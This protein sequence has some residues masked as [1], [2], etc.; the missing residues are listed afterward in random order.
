MRSS[1]N[2]LVFAILALTSLAATSVYQCPMHP[3]IKA[4]TKAKCTI[5]GM[6]LVVAQPDAAAVPA[7]T[8][9]LS[10]S[11]VTTVGVE[12]DT[13]GIRPLTRTLRVLG[14]IEDDDTRHRLVTAWADG[15]V[16]KLHANVIGATLAAGSP[17]LD[18]Y[19]PELQVAQREFVQLARAG[20]LT[21]PAL[22][23]AR[24]R[25]RKLGLA[26]VQLDELLRTGEPT[27]VTTLLAPTGGTIVKKDVYEG[28]WIKGGD[29]LLELADFSEMWFVFE[30]YEPDIAWLR[31][32]QSVA[33]SLRSLPGEVITAPIAFIDPNF[34][35]TTLTTKARAVLANPHLAADG[36][37]HQL[38]HR[39]SA[40]ARV[41]LDSPSALTVPRSA[42]L[43]T[44]SG[45]VTY[46]ETASG[47]YETRPLK[48][49]RRGDTLVEVLSG[50]RA[51]ERV[52]TTGALLVDAQAQL[53]R[54]A[55]GAAVVVAQPTATTE[56]LTA[57]ADA[58]AAGAA[59]LAADD[60]AAYQTA[61][62]SLIAASKGF[63]QLPR[64]ESGDALKTAR[65]SFEP[66][67]TAVADLLR[68][69]RAEL[70]LH[71]FQ[72]PMAP[73]LGKGRWVQREAKLR[74]PFF[75]AAMASCGNELP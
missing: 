41:A 66:W 43:D 32:G 22:P 21:A 54:E 75:G 70:G 47:R 69:R 29:R 38:F 5:C 12:T 60:F 58:A 20:E 36:T 74:N 33:I 67:S 14:T 18:L 55:A 1:L 39:V 9:A 8:I 52:V 10:P 62:P 63:P 13:V 25:L 61:L 24:A 59:A 7:G 57:L 46:V 71:V 65:R 4:N 35:A 30:V 50:V 68:P 48:L 6:D 72:C 56:Q 23:A 17:L 27:L 37:R 49:G 2:C 44:G 73:V 34:N 28:Q 64:L 3:W 11:I 53:A 15:R 19:S 42:V 40:E 45:P 31:L 16:E 26:E 51:G